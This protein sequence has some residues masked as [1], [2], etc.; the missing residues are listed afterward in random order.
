ML[1]E[2]TVPRTPRATS[3]LGP[4]APW[5]YVGT[6]VAVELVREVGT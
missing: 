4:A 1:K 3:S 6:A 5:H 2:Y